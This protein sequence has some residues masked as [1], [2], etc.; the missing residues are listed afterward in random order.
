M[1]RGKQIYNINKADVQNVCLS[2]VTVCLYGTFNSYNEDP[3]I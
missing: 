2:F 1:Q 3:I